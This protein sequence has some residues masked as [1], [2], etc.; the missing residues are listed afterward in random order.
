[1]FKAIATIV[2]TLLVSAIVA[3]QTAPP[4]NPTV[5]LRGAIEK[6]V[7]GFIT[8]KERRGETIKLVTADNLPMNEVYPFKMEGIKQAVTLALLLCQNQ[9]G[10]YGYG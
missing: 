7:P 1:M 8:I 3:A 9:M 6:L 2:G 10:R 4:A 5:R